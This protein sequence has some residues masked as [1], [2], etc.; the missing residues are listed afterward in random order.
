M[1]EKDAV[2]CRDLNLKNAWYLPIHAEFTEA[3]QYR[4]LNLLKG[5]STNG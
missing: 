4:L 1:T 5:S 3:F 2:K